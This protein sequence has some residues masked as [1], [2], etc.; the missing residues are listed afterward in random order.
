VRR[1]RIRAGVLNRVDEPSMRQAFA[2]VS[3]GTVADGA[4]VDLEVVPLLVECAACGAETP[5]DEVPVACPR[6]GDLGVQLRGGDELTLV[7]IDV[8]PTSVSG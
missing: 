8:A 6:C 7:S 2:L 4:E 5:S 3:E 1:V